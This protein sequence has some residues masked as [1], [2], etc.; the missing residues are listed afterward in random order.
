MLEHSANSSLE[1]RLQSKWAS[2][3]N[4]NSFLD[5]KIFFIQFF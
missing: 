2:L 3:D 1:E 5:D 4:V